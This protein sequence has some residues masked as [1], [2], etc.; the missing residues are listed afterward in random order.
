M[1]NRGVIIIPIFNKKPKKSKESTQIEVFGGRASSIDINAT[2]TIAQRQTDLLT[3]LRRTTNPYDAIELLVNEHPDASMAYQM[4]LSLVS[5]GGNIEFTSRGRT[6]D[7]IK[8]EWD[9]FA[10][11]V[12]KLCANGLE[13]I[14]YQLHSSDFL[15]GGMACEVV[16]TPDMSDIEDIYVINPKTIEWKLTED[17][18]NYYPVQKIN[19]KEIDLRTANF[20]WIPFNPKIANPQGSLLFRSA[21]SAADMQLEFF[22]SSQQVLYRVGCPRY[23]V[24]LDIEKIMA[25]APPEVRNDTTGQ[26]QTTYINTII[27]EARNSLTKIGVT[28][29]FVHT[30]DM[31]ITTTGVNNAAFFQGISAYAEIIDTQMMNS[32]KILG[33]L[34]NRHQNGG[35]YALGTVEFKSI[36]DMLEPRQRAE[37]RIVESIARIWLQVNGYNATA[38]YTPNPI[39]W[40]TFK[41]KVEYLLKNL[42][43]NRR[44]NE[45]GYIDE[46]MAAQKSMQV[47]KAAKPNKNLFEYIKKWFDESGE[48]KNTDETDGEENT[49]ENN[50]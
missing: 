35:S 10:F 20:L 40:Q 24:S 23:D 13:G 43:L 44:A 22:K 7:N 12:G 32:L 16:L 30:N 37:K 11:R 26:Q 41:D 25:S 36:C 50:S 8:E 1:K 45:Y 3:K 6:S 17:K 9:N 19:G 5:Q 15:A 14:V 29:D 31:N 46:D 49:E 48:N 34:M 39:E 27:S 28:R 42:E 18:Q 2:T 47:E 4:L 21:I 33:T 38:K